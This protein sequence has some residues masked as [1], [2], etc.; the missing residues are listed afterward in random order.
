VDSFDFSFDGTTGRYEV[1]TALRGSDLLGDPMLNKGTGFDHAE[2]E[3]FNLRGFLPH[4]VSPFAQQVRRITASIQRKSDPLE[5]YI[6]L[7]AL[8]DRNEHLYYRVLLDHFEEFLPIVYTPTVGQA[9]KEFS[10][11]FRRGRGLWITPEH[12]GRIA[13][14]LRNSRS[15]QVRLMVVTDN[16]SILGIGDQGAG[17]MAISV[18]KLALYV[19]GAGIHP[20]QTLPISLDVGTNNAAL[21]AD[22]LYLGVRSP[23]LTGPAYDALVE[24]FVG[25]VRVVFPKALIQWEDFRKENALNIL[26]RYRRR[27][28]SFNDDIQGTGAVALAGVMTGCRVLNQKLRDQR[29]VILG[30]G[31]A[32]MGIANQ[33]RAAFASEGLDAAGQKRAVALIDS[34]G[35]LVNDRPIQ[36]EYKRDLAWPP[37]VAASFGLGG[38]APRDLA[39]VVA[40]YKPTVLIGASGQGGAFT[41]AV[42]RR[43]AEHCARPMIFPFS[44]PTDCCEA[45]PQMLLDWTNGRALIATGSPFPPVQHGGRTI[46]I[47][48]GNNVF[49]FPALGLGTLLSQAREVTDNMITAAARALAAQITNDELKQGLLY[50]AI[51]RLREVC[52][53]Q[54][55]AVMRQAV[56]DG[57]APEPPPGENL[58]Q[59]VRAAMWQPRYPKLIPV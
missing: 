23:R 14:V 16:E 24:E 21:L 57:V 59:R 49:I 35:L 18:G 52:A 54:T 43:M 11:A 31:A 4:A 29:V 53:A 26:T 55:A 40:A 6:G 12:R 58:E 38:E 47:G 8:Q 9:C 7:A 30:A 25:A 15:A 36:D 34:R 2:R 1:R 51:P 41:E 20:W 44:N 17:G 50:P 27:V 13:S 33:L 56:A 42:V 39:A 37:E 5:K 22:D 10:N 45:I 46:R 19:A 48:Q 3:A 28:L 32:G